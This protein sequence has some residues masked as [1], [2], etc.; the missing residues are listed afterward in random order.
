MIN[1]LSNHN[2]TN[3]C[4]HSKHSTVLDGKLINVMSPSQ[5]M[6][7]QYLLMPT[8]LSCA[9]LLLCMSKYL[10]LPYSWKLSRDKSFDDYLFQHFANK[11]SGYKVFFTNEYCIK[12]IFIFE[13]RSTS[14]KVSSY[15]VMPNC[16]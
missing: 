9:D 15:T 13:D 16:I 11:F 3:S 5:N 7:L 6:I 8:K 1:Y 10:V 12:T 2:C 4:K 14:T